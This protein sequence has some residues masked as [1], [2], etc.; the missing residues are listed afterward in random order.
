MSLRIEL[1]PAHTDAIQSIVMR[2]LTQ[3]L[4][5]TR[6]VGAYT[7]KDWESHLTEEALEEYKKGN[8]P[9]SKQG[10]LVSFDN[11]RIAPKLN[12][13]IQEAFPGCSV[14]PSG[15]FH[16]PPTGYMGWHTNSD[17][18]CKRLYITWT[19]EA[20]KSFFRYLQNDVITTDYDS[21]GFTFRLFNITDKPPYLW[22]CVGSNTD[23]IS[24]GYQIS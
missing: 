12:H 20:N 8:T 22:H 21:A 15:F 7:E 2:Y 16:Y 17:V 23:R 4:G 5:N 14:K 3:I 1:S 24:I 19:K 11:L 6:R 13:I 10:N 9:I 18:P